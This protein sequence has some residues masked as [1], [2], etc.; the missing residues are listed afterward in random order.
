MAEEVKEPVIEEKTPEIKADAAPVEDKPVEQA[1]E[2]GLD[3]EKTIED[4]VKILNIVDENIG[5]KG[6]ITNIP[7]ELRGAIQYIVDQLVFVRETFKDELWS[8]ILD[9]MKDQKEDGKT[10]SVLVAIARNVPIA[11]IQA[12]SESEDYEG[13][14]NELTSS[15]EAKKKASDE[16]AEFESSFE[17]SK[18]AGEEYAAEMGYDEDEKNALFQDVIDLFKIMADGIITKEEFKRV[19]KMR[20]YDKDIEDYKS[21]IQPGETK[22][23]LPDQ[24]SVE[25]AIA[26][27]KTQKQTPKQTPGLSS[28]SVYNNAVT[29]V[30][31]IGKRTRGRK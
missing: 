11:D 13:A 16:E 2:E 1:S 17:A 29:D 27:P 10:P 15:L 12:I 19:D 6:E 14:Q 18:K 22:E 25:A 30:T 9:D 20:N 28:M 31:E 24:S 5:G 23:V 4:A 8:A 7:D 21:Q 3:A 26:T